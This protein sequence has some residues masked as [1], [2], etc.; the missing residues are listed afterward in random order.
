MIYEDN[1]KD[2]KPEDIAAAALH[3]IANNVGK[4]SKLTISLYS[5]PSCK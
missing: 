3:M 5:T 4:S 2:V 1:K